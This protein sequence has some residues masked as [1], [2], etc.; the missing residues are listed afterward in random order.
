MSSVMYDINASPGRAAGYH[1]PRPPTTAASSIHQQSPSSHLQQQQQQQQ[2]QQHRVSPSQSS[3]STSTIT[4]AQYAA[5]YQQQ[6]QQQQLQQYHHHHHQQQGSTS[7]PITPP[8]MH[9][10]V[11]AGYAE[12]RVY[13]R[14]T[15]LR[16]LADFRLPGSAY[17]SSPNPAAVAI[18][19]ASSS[20]GQSTPTF[21]ATVAFGLS[22]I[23]KAKAEPTFSL[24]VFAHAFDD[25]GYPIYSGRAAELAAKIH[26]P[27]NVNADVEVTTFAY[28][29]A[30][31]SAAVWDGVV[32]LPAADTGD[33][34]IFSVKD[35][36]EASSGNVAVRP[37]DV[38]PSASHTPNNTITNPTPEDYVLTV[39]L[40]WQLPV[41]ASR[42]VIDGQAQTV[43]VALPPSFEL[44]R[45]DD[46]A[47]AS[48]AN[49]ASSLL[50][51][52]TSAASLYRASPPN[53]S[54]GATTLGAPT[55]TTVTPKKSKAKTVRV[56]VER[57]LESV[58]RLGC[59]YAV[60]FALVARPEPGK[61]KSEKSSKKSD[62]KEAIK[63]RVLDFI[64]LPFIFV[65]EQTTLPLPAQALPPSL[66]PQLLYNPEAK[67]AQDWQKH[68]T[69][70]KWTGM[71]LKAL[72]RA[73]QLDLHLPT[74]PAFHA[75]SA[76][77]FLLI[78]RPSDASLLPPAPSTPPDGDWRSQV[79]L[80]SQLSSLRRPA[81]APTITSTGSPTGSALTRTTTSTAVAG[82]VDLTRVVRISLV[83]VVYSTTPNVNDLPVRKRRIMSVA[84]EV[85]EV[86]LQAFLADDASTSD[87]QAI[88]DAQ[89]SGV[90]VL[91]G[92]L[93]VSP[94]VTPS[95]RSQGIEVKYAVKVDLLPFSGSSSSHS[96]GAAGGSG[97]STLGRSEKENTSSAS[98]TVGS[99]SSAMKSLR[100][101]RS[102]SRFGSS[103]ASSI[104]SGKSRRT[105][106]F[107]DGSGADQ[108]WDATASM[109][110]PNGPSVG[111]NGGVGGR[112]RDHDPT[113]TQFS[114]SANSPPTTPPWANSDGNGHHH[115]Q[116]QPLGAS[117]NANAAAISQQ[118]PRSISEG[119]G[120]A[121]HSVQPGAAHAGGSTAA[122]SHQHIN[123]GVATAASSLGEELDSNDSGLVNGHV[124]NGGATHAAMAARRSPPS[125]GMAQQQQ[126]QGG[127]S[128][129][130]CLPN[131]T[132]HMHASNR[133]SVAS[134]AT[135]VAS[136]VSSPSAYPSP[137]PG[138]HS[139]LY[140]GGSG[141][142][143][144]GYHQPGN[145][146]PFALNPDVAQVV[147][148]ANG[149]AGA[150][151]GAATVQWNGGMSPSASSG[152]GLASP[153]MGAG[154]VLNGAGGG[155]GGGGGG[156]SHMP[157]ASMSYAPSSWAPS[158]ASQYGRWGAGGAHSTASPTSVQA[159]AETERNQ[160]AKLQ[161]TAG[162]LW[163]DI[164]VVRG[165]DAAVALAHMTAPYGVGI[166]A[167]GAYRP[168]TS[169]ASVMGAAGWNQYSGSFVG[170]GAGGGNGSPGTHG[171]AMMMMPP[172]PLP[173]QMAP[174][175]NTRAS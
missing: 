133:F 129:V 149:G 43:H 143:S 70:T 40:T 20:S 46:P 144:S 25:R 127:K 4:A 93:R 112:V 29:T 172:P 9:T 120:L 67:L 175:P 134:S 8:A 102:T 119:T 24:E 154:S 109:P 53:S 103:Y 131:G 60:Q 32:L 121:N 44:T 64:T 136:T 81:T 92:K 83:Q 139:V 110:A 7:S 68:H 158:S 10:P 57:T 151:A 18:S 17:N 34:N 126:Q 104:F 105:R 155:G 123:G 160:L 28:T 51:S 58:T 114:I 100:L 77:P 111:G 98:S 13:G 73:I 159:D 150:G 132:P 142:A 113:R 169:A 166:G 128:G 72:R 173:S 106:G 80:S 49:S 52:S 59:F 19:S 50:S 141:G 101:K 145:T 39:P 117:F 90:R 75:P 79:G 137:R 85:E 146:L 122:G 174:P 164:R 140:G 156:I 21:S 48:G 12:S 84:Q 76:I 157:G 171:S 6:Q 124:R 15:D 162:S 88:A 22:L 86:D 54:S 152:M 62:K 74:G 147:A 153:L 148:A 78:I 23:G 125:P 163:V 30:G 94:H 63:D 61:E 55:I 35:R 87:E 165:S 45:S 11:F 97:A 3:T 5:Q 56:I 118:L 107:S 170:G 42:T 99:I 115:H 167:A 1:L 37:P 26:M 108:G 138:L 91:A 161:K 14:T 38:G 65:G 41:G 33:R 36:F 16:K 2:Q 71:M 69:V 31:S 27:A 82:T 130:P 116:A 66:R 47:D 135:D 95:F 89:R 168:G 96:N